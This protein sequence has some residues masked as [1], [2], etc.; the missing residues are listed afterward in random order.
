MFARLRFALYRFVLGLVTAKGF[1]DQ[2]VWPLEIPARGHIEVE[3]L[4]PELPRLFGAKNFPATEHADERLKEIKQRARLLPLVSKLPAAETGP[5]SDVYDRFLDQVYPDRYRKIWST[6]PAVP[7]ELESDDMLAA[8]AVSGPFAMYLEKGSTVAGLDSLA[9]GAAGSDDYVIDMTVFDGHEAK[10]GLLAPGG[11]GVFVLDGDR[12]R[13]KGVVY[14]GELHQPGDPEFA[15]ASRLLLCA[16]NTHLTTL[17]H[18]VTFH[19]GYVTPMAVASTNDLS[20]DHPIRRLLHPA[21]QTTLIGNHEVAAFQ[22]VGR[23]SFATKLFSH[24]YP[25]LVT[26]INEHLH[27]FRPV[28]LDPEIEFARRGLV[29]AHMELPFWDDALALWQINLDYANSYVEHYYSDDDAVAQD[30]ELVAWAADLDQLLP[31]GL[32]DD[33]DY[34]VAGRPLTRVTLARLCAAFLH[35]SSVTHDVVNNAV[36][37]YSTLNYVVPTVVPESLEHQDVR[38]SFD[39]MNTIFGTW[40]RFN[41]LIDGVSVL[42]LD[43]AGRAIM[44]DYVQALRGRQAE[45]DAEP[46]RAGRIYPAALNPSVS[47]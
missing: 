3:P 14:G 41:M 28:D 1:K 17:T 12:L 10:P 26:L 39:L 18:N 44:D 35:V 25:T 13:T 22:I 37:D 24:D 42:A 30:G 32:Y 38:L 20:P 6:A 4:S 7:P 19:L 5:V 36:W 46:R 47:N 11:L 23:N 33:H 45:M 34:L 16:M 27:G 40:K 31:S 15:R 9:L 8:L 21:F 2:R 29:D 43:D